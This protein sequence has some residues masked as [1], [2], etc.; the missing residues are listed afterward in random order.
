[1]YRGEDNICENKLAKEEKMCR[2]SRAREWGPE[3]TNTQA[4]THSG[5]LKH[6][7]IMHIVH[8]QTCNCT[9]IYLTHS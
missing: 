7:H 6:S 5:I 9:L 4:L 1:M 3:H 2:L 8:M